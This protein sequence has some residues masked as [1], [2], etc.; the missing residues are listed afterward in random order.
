MGYTQ[1]SEK[2]PDIAKPKRARRNQQ[3]NL[4]EKLFNHLLAS[5]Q[6]P[7]EPTLAC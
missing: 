4:L 7:V 5:L 2:A 3:L 1:S 6:M